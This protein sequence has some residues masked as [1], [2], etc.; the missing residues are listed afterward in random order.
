VLQAHATMV[1]VATADN[2]VAGRDNSNVLWDRRVLIVGRGS[3]KVTRDEVKREVVEVAS[4][5]VEEVRVRAKAVQLNEYGE[6]VLH[7]LWRNR[8]MRG[9]QLGL[10]VFAGNTEATRSRRIHTLLADLAEHGFVERVWLPG[11]GSAA[12]VLGDI[13]R[14]W[15]KYTAGLQYEVRDQVAILGS[16]GSKVLHDVLIADFMVPIKLDI[17]RL[18]GDFQWLVGRDNRDRKAHVTVMWDAYGE[19]TFCN[20]RL[21]FFVEIDRQTENLARLGEKVEKY[22][23]YYED[24]NWSELLGVDEFPEILLVTSGGEQRLA[25]MVGEIGRQ[26]DRVDNEDNLVWLLTNFER[27]ERTVGEMYNP[28]DAY[29]WENISCSEDSNNSYNA[30]MGYDWMV[31]A[32]EA[33]ITRLKAQLAESDYAPQQAGLKT[34][35]TQLQAQRKLVAA[36]VRGGGD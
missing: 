10:I 25:N 24:G 6:R 11:G 14:A 12:Y 15:I 5:S 28:L 18:G 27:L 4:V 20:E 35:L 13:G 8:V 2:S 33:E 36:R 26:L 1:S 22:H 16:R 7:L 21:A 30:V 19:I 34:R 17:E 9:V 3:G 32:I 31:E 23:R 29:I